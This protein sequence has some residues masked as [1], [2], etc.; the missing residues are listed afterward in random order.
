LARSQERR[1]RLWSATDWASW[2]T[3]ILGTVFLALLTA[4]V[5]VLRHELA[6][7]EGE[8][9]ALG[10]DLG[11][12]TRAKTSGDLELQALKRPP[13][14][15]P[16]LDHREMAMTEALGLLNLGRSE[17]AI[18][19]F[20]YVIRIDPNNSQA[21]SSLGYALEV[22]GRFEEAIEADRRAIALDGMN[23][24]AHWNLGNALYN[25]G[26]YQG[27]ASS[28]RKALEISPSYTNAYVGLGNALMMLGR[29]DEAR[30]EFEKARDPSKR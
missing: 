4:P 23:V 3:L 30:Q 20:E 15:D 21:Y 19:A 5:L 11:K 17:Q 2:A 28:H 1:K 22:T 12:V 6:V 24:G 25:I 10:E 27:A 13:T 14:G 26:D 9:R 18:P 16:S 29:E 7:Q 8:S